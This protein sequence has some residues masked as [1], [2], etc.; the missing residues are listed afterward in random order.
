MRTNNKLKSHVK[1]GPGMEPRPQRMEGKRFYL[2]AS[3]ATNK[4]PKLIHMKKHGIRQN[5]YLR[6]LDSCNKSIVLK[7]HPVGL[8]KF[9]SN[10][11]VQILQRELLINISIILRHSDHQHIQK[12]RLKTASL[13]I[14][15]PNL[16]IY[17]TVRG[18][19]MRIAEFPGHRRKREGN[20]RTWK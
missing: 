3:P 19:D 17:I 14:S 7:F 6:T 11:E 1:P 2:C 16:L 12:S 15:S 8:I 9:G 5:R 4:R 20:G 10:Q 18:L 13:F